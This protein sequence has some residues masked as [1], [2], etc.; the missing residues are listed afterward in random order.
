[1]RIRTAA[2]LDREAAQDHLEHELIDFI[3]QVT[4]EVSWYMRERGLTRADLAERMGVSPGRVSQI[5]GG[6][7]NLTARTLIALS[8]ALDARF[9]VEL[10]TPKGGDSYT[11]QDPAQAEAA[12]P[13]N[14]HAAP[15]ARHRATRLGRLNLCH[16]SWAR[17]GRRDPCPVAGE[18]SGSRSRTWRSASTSPGASPGTRGPP[19]RAGTPTPRAGRGQTPGAGVAEADH[20]PRACG[21]IL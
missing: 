14:R 6:G 21:V 5:L 16:L 11:S 20:T 3:T 2:S 17:S 19:G 13:A 9:D 7:E 12:P 8:T 1:M 15:R 4:N 18:R 10:T